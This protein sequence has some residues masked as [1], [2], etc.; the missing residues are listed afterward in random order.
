MKVAPRAATG[1][2]LVE[3]MIGITVGL[4]ILL[5][6]SSL[7]VSQLG[8]HRRLTLETRTEQDLRVLAELMRQDLQR[9]GVWQRPTLGVWSELNPNPQANPNADV[10]I[11]AGGTSVLVRFWDGAMPSKQVGY[12]LDGQ[13]V[14]RLDGGWQ[15]VTD[16]DTVKITR[17]NARLEET[18]LSMESA[19]ALPCDGAANCPPTV[20][21]RELIIRVEAEAAHDA[22]VKR[23]FDVR[24]RLP[25]DRMTGVC[26]AS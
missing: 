19:C 5:G 9:S 8:D 13:L 25:A 12:R 21:M 10:N 3:L 6:A 2:S 18:P 11:G 22:L 14:R 16:A 17:F 4:F 7:M 23:N 1:F 24:V 20:Q 15:P 26:R